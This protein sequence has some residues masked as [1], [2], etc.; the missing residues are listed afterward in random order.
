MEVAQS[1]SNVHV[2]LSLTN[3]RSRV[4]PMPFC[5][6]RAPPRV[7]ARIFLYAPGALS[8][9]LPSASMHMAVCIGG[10]HAWYTPVATVHGALQSVA[11]LCSVRQRSSNLKEG[12][13]GPHCPLAS[14]ELAVLCRTSPYVTITVPSRA[15]T[16]CT[17]HGHLLVL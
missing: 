12:T 2:L 10:S 5:S 6:V 7:G 1:C 8:K 11:T 16:A 9:V 17:L 3:Q 13:G 14:R 15:V 4:T